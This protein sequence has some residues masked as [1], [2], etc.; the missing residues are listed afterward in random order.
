MPYYNHIY[1][2]RDR[3]HGITDINAFEGK[4]EENELFLKTLQH[5]CNEGEAYCWM[6]CKSL[7]SDCNQIEDAVCVDGHMLRCK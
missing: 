3:E 6:I 7:P 4:D 2:N 5:Q 1:F